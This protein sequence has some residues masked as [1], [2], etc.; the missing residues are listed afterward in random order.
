MPRKKTGIGEYGQERLRK[1]W[2]DIASDSPTPSWVVG[3]PPSEANQ[4][5]RDQIQSGNEQ[6]QEESSAQDTQTLPDLWPDKSNYYQGPTRSTRVSRHRFVLNKTNGAIPT[7]LGT[8]FVKF[9]NMRPNGRIRR[10][11]VYAYFDVPFSIYKSFTSTNSKGQ[12]INH[13]LNNYQYANLNKDESVFTT[14]YKD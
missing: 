1:N 8:V 12:F 14:D 10:E 2:Q 11:D 7:N 13:T 9:T 4:R 3:G 6:F 5:L